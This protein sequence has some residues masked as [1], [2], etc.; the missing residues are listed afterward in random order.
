MLH[1]YPFE[2]LR[3]LRRRALLTQRDVQRL[4]GISDST[5]A[6][7]E[8]GRRK[9]QTNTPRKLLNIYGINISRWEHQEQTWEAGKEQG[10]APPAAQAAGPQRAGRA[11]RSQHDEPPTVRLPQLLS[12]SHRES[13]FT[14]FR[15]SGA[16]SYS[17][18]R[19]NGR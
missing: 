8:R 7:L 18:R 1:C 19:T 12:L 5:F 6:Y 4:T 3:E 17:Y 16:R 11:A 15:P 9:P 14:R 10:G 2:K 13:A